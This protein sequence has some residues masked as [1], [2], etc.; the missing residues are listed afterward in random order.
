MSTRE[1]PFFKQDIYYQQ[2]APKLIIMDR[3]NGTWDGN[4][5]NCLKRREY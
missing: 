1:D 5:K 4:L 3:N 2:K